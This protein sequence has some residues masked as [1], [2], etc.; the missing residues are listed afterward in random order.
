MSDD[1][2]AADID[3]Q[4]AAILDALDGA[5]TIEALMA[6]LLVQAA[7]IRSLSEACQQT[8]LFDHAQTQFADFKSELEAST[9]P[10]QR[11]P[12][13]WLWLLD[14]IVAA[15]TRIHMRGAVRLC[16]PLVA[17]YLPAQCTP[18]SKSNRG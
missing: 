4:M 9:T 16:L 15:P 2:L 7:R 17:S 11:L 14:R 3:A 10:A 12:T 5:D 1:P 13:S 6:G 18:V 8:G